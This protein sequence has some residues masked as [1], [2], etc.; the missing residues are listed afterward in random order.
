MREVISNGLR[1]QDLRRHVDASALDSWEI[2]SV[3]A[4]RG[5]RPFRTLILLGEVDA[6][7]GRA[8][9]AAEKQNEL[10]LSRASLRTVT[11][12]QA[13][14]WGLIAGFSVIETP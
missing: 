12:A 9:L 10:D 11:Y 2:L 1:I 4:G 3:P 14:R 6:A 5:K 7:V 8:K 13:K